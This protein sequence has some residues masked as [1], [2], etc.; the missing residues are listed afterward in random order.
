VCRGI[1]PDVVLERGE[2]L[3]ALGQCA[4]YETIPILS[5]GN[6]GGENGRRDSERRD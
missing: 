4:Q 5:E 1:N 2:K 3:A 6:V